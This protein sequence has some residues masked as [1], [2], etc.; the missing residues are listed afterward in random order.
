MRNLSRGAIGARGDRA[1]E[2]ILA[3]GASHALQVTGRS[4]R[5]C[6]ETVES[7]TGLARAADSTAALSWIALCR[8]VLAGSTRL[9]VH[10]GCCC[11]PWGW[12]HS[13]R[14]GGKGGA[15]CRVKSARVIPC[16]TGR[17][18]LL[19]RFD[20]YI[21]STL[22]IYEGVETNHFLLKNQSSISGFRSIVNK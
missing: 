10:C 8:G 6:D 5:A 13:G 16:D 18:S 12:R 15:A 7:A 20:G 14:S 19:S 2:T 1:S 9:A 11:R 21:R 22:W 4:A 3:D 17:P